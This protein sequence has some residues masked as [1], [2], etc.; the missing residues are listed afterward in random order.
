MYAPS[1][2]RGGAAAPAVPSRGAL[3]IP[4]RYEFKY[5]IPASMVDEAREAIRPY[6]A[7]DR[8][9]A[10]VP[11]RSYVIHS[12]YFDTWARDLYR[13]SREGRP[14]NMK[15]RVRTYGEDG[16]APFFLEVKRKEQGFILKTRARVDASWADRLRG[17]PPADMTNDEQLFRDVLLRH[18]LEPA[19]LVAYRREA[20]AS[21]VDEYARV[22]FDRAITCQPWSRWDFAG[23]RDAWLPLDA[24]PPVRLVPRPV[25][26][27]LKATLDF[28]RWMTALVARLALV[29]TGY[30]KYCVGVERIWGGSARDGGNNDG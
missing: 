9:C 1:S 29:R 18:A 13:R 23:P 16:R 14:R 25:V 5:V 26:L 6:C 20:W 2:P 4:R 11:E 30:S 22:T 17:S 12:L 15:V 10:G 24:G 27:E 3:A 28:P 19:L 8:H 7:L 21:E